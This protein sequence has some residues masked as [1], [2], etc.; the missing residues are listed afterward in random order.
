MPYGLKD[1]K[2]M[3]ERGRESIFQQILHL[4]VDVGF[5][6]ATPEEVD[7][8][9]AYPALQ[10]S[11]SRALNEIR[12][13]SI[14]H[15]IIDGDN[16]VNSWKGGIAALPKA[17]RDHW[18]VSAASVVAKVFRDRLMV[19]E[20]SKFPEYLWASNK[21][22]GSGEHMQAIRTFGSLCRPGAYYHRKSYIKNIET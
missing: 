2:S 4:S 16:L 17:D 12:H 11:Y 13:V 22:Y 7:T 1:S 21:G 5:G 15:V 18:Q 3:T 10:K 8:L 6:W 9:G 20:S 14:D 19:Q